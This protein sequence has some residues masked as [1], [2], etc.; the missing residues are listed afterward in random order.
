MLLLH[1]P[2]VLLVIALGVGSAMLIL[3][4]R[5][6]VA[7]RQ[8]ARE[9]AHSEANLLALIENSHD[10]VWSVDRNFT[11]L[12]ANSTFRRHFHQAFGVELHKGMNL[13]AV[14]P[15]ELAQT[16]RALYE[17]ALAG[18]HFTVE[19]HY[20]FADSCCDCEISFNPI[21]G[22]AGDITGVSV[23]GRDITERNRDRQ[24]LLESE[25]RYR[26]LVDLSP[27]TVLVLS[28]GNVVYVN[29]AGARMFGAGSPQEMVGRSLHAYLHPD[30]WE[31]LNCRLIR[32]PGA[33]QIAELI[34]ES[35]VRH[36]G[37][38][39]EA[40][41]VAVTITFQGRPASQV[42]IRDITERKRAER[43]LTGQKHILELIARGR[44][45]PEVLR[46]LTQFVEARVPD[47]CCAVMRYDAQR[48]CLH[49]GAG[50]NLPATL[51][52]ALDGM[53]IN[54]THGVCAAAVF[55]K[56]QIISAKLTA[57]GLPESTSGT[58]PSPASANG[59]RAA[60]ACWSTPILTAN[61]EVLGT[62]DL[63]FAAP[64]PPTP[65]DFELIEIA[66]QLAE[67]AL[68]RERARE[69]LH[70]AKEMAE[71]A[72]RTKSQF[73]ANMSHEIRTPMNGILGMTEL[74]LETNLTAEQREYLHLVKDSAEAL[75]V[76]L[77]DILDFSK[78]EAGKLELEPIDFHLRETLGDTI[79]PLGLRAH[80]KGLELICHILPEVPDVLIGDPGRLRQI[81]VNL[82]G[83]AIKFTE[84]GE[85]VVT[86]AARQ[87]TPTS[88]L[89]QFSVAD[90]GIGIP[91]DKHEIIFAPFTQ[92]DN[93]TTRRFGG[94]GL[95]LAICTQLVALMG[96]KIWVE[97]EVGRGSVF[98]FTAAFQL[99]EHQLADP[100]AGLAELAGVPVLIVEDN[101]TL[102]QVLTA[103]LRDWGLQPLAVAS[104]QAAQLAC[105]R[106][107]TAGQPFSLAVIDTALDDLDGFALAARLIET[108]GW[109]GTVIML[110]SPARL[111]AQAV[112]CRELGIR[113]YLTK[114]VKLT[115][116]AEAL[117]TSH[118][119]LAENAGSRQT[120]HPAREPGRLHILI[121][122]DDEINQ[123][124]AARLLEK[125][126][127]TV[128]TVGN[129]NDAVAAFRNE[130]FDLILMDIQMPAL[131]G[132]EAIFAIR[133]LEKLTGGRTPIV[134]V[135]AY[136][137]KGDRERC[138][139][140][141]VD[142]YISKPLHVQELM[143]L[144][145]RLTPVAMIP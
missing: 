100:F 81:I 143:N 59:R 4:R 128:V 72:S 142:A 32:T 37:R 91:A 124:L 50:P 38:V 125:C 5:H 14:V 11:L 6:V 39:I 17:R 20:D 60:H 70:Q 130:R 87:L 27:E 120:R 144:I 118:R 7:L 135:T 75:M 54:P 36:D 65:G 68:E 96:G 83:N 8:H 140:A 139:A 133:E 12:T 28:A 101:A 79:A 64:Q 71:I 92:G 41:I 126:G 46:A 31:K 93:S 45:L 110:L 76:L 90:T 16:W 42:L 62:L 106:S 127:H 98:H 123:R 21:R 22:P 85:I 114:P 33:G 30:C 35:I 112:R 134:A 131:G 132:F 51:A 56:K 129:G 105:N 89:L 10:S 109:S 115:D 57:A 34:E 52:A 116:L 15:P 80:Q 103:T 1:I 84:T 23:F 121:A 86:V 82:V 26:S 117:L 24:A 97:S 88:A 19:Q 25:E 77:N 66:A 49:L 13:L 122:E 61:G 53:P 55:H 43:L 18:E 138:L 102:R 67:I 9:L 108:T 99:P 113:H 141:G 2:F 95:G 44:P 74:A 94:T 145:A 73:V 111:H 78:I 29:D 136:A 137:M 104:S 48:D 107:R 119:Q 63:Y 3:R 40:E 69:Q 58:P 47:S